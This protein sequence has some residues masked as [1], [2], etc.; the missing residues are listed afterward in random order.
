VVGDGCRWGE[1]GGKNWVKV[2]GKKTFLKIL[3]KS[4]VLRWSAC[5]WIFFLIKKGLKTC[6]VGCEPDKSQTPRAC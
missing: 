5:F 3:G 2:L 1:G 4:C 6:H